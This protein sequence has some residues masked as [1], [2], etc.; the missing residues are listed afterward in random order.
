VALDDASD[1]AEL[2]GDEERDAVCEL[3][4]S[5]VVGAH[6]GE[7]LAAKLITAIVAQVGKERAVRPVDEDEGLVAGQATD[8]GEAGEV[9]VWA[10]AECGERGAEVLDRGEEGAV[11]EGLGE[12]LWEQGTVA[13]A[14]GSDSRA[15]DALSRV[16]RPLGSERSDAAH[17][18]VL[19]RDRLADEP[20]PKDG[21]AGG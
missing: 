3:A 13:G 14:K 6:E 15:G 21:E 10:G 18:R 5:L 1:M 19:H 9:A 20:A 17:E 4:V 12:R 7:K 16:G 2:G 8:A 11:H